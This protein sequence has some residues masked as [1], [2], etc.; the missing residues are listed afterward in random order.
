ME[1]GEEMKERRGIDRIGYHNTDF[2]EVAFIN[3]T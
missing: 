1:R 3:E 2:F